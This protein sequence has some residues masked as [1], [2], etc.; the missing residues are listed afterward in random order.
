MSKAEPSFSE[1]QRLARQG[2]VVPVYRTIVADM[3]SPVAAFLKLTGEVG[4]RGA[5]PSGGR[6][7]AVRPYSFLLESVEGGEHI[8]RYTY[9]GAEP[10][11]VVR[12]RGERITV[13]RG[14]ARREE[15]GKVFDFLRR[16]SAQYRAVALPGLPPFT[17]GAVGYLSYEAV[18]QLERL[19][20]R[21]PPDVEMD[22]AVFLYFTNLAAFDHVQH[23]LFLIS[24]VLTEE[25]NPSA[26]AHAS[27]SLSVP[28]QGRREAG[29]PQPNR[30]GL[31]AKY[32]AAVREL[33]RMERRLARPLKLPRPRRPAGPLRV[34][35]NMTRERFKAMVE[36][37]KE[38]IRAGDVFQVVLSQRLEVPV[39]VPPFDVYRALRVVNPSPYMYYLRLGDVTV[40]G[41]SPEMLVKVAGRDVEYRPIA[42]TR[43]RGR[44]EEEDK[45]LEQEMLAD[46]KERA[47]HIMLVD[48]GRNDIGRVSEFSS[49][50][51]ERIMFV[52]RY[53]HV[54]HLVSLLR[55]RLRPDADSTAALAACFPAGTLT[56]APKV[57]AMEIID[58]LE[59][60]R[61]GLY[62]GAIFYADFSG[63]L[64]SCIVIRTLLIRGSKA[65]LQ[66]GAGIVADSVPAREY[67]ESMNKA[68]AVLK[69]F[70]M[71]EKGL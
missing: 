17:V 16:M 49:V 46:E 24:N 33:D 56:G 10:F 44:M 41:S 55:G 3:L 4:A 52:E 67:E 18:R 5:R 22:D 19:P 66:A 53:S 54:M 43:P 30:A 1:F 31:R 64:N 45:R 70:E 6:A 21:V 8:G 15:T 68:R 42:G 62:G 37:G 14:N 36:R 51:P 71:A 26:S 7:D 48:L 28:E 39:R 61:R 40:L 47:E 69:A 38:Y 25:G 13:E 12:C 60:T 50:K 11:Q 58:E 59:P 65:Y 63:N 57:R 20:A 34:R 2:N 23:R 29:E 9:F 32:H 35:S 27:T